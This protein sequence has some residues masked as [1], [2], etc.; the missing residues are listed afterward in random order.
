MALMDMVKV[1]QL[2]SALTQLLK[3]DERFVSSV[4]HPYFNSTGCN[5][6]VE[7][8]DRGGELITTYSVKVAEHIGPSAK[9]VLGIFGQPTPQYY[10]H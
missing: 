2:I 7:E 8:E 9:K 1:E 4:T 6:V 3:V 10:F 5:K